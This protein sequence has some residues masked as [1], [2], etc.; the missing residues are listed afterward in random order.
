L[1]RGCGS[2][3]FSIVDRPVFERDTYVATLVENSPP[4]TRVAQ[5]R[6]TDADIGDNGRIMY[7]LHNGGV[8]AITE[9]GG[10]RPVNRDGGSGISS[11]GGGGTFTIDERTGV[12][13]VSGV[14]DYESHPTGYRLMVTARDCGSPEMRSA[15]A[16][17]VIRIVDVNDNAP[18]VRVNTIR[19]ADAERASVPEDAA[20][21][22]FVAHV[23]ATD[24]DAGENGRVECRLTVDRQLQQQ[25]LLLQ[26]KAAT[27]V[28]EPQLYFRLH[29][30][31][32][33]EYHL[34]TGG[35]PLDRELYS[36]SE[37]GLLHNTRTHA[38]TRTIRRILINNHA[39]R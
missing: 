18:T 9:G 29:A 39:I 21:D 4:G 15:D 30:T 26:R 3:Q 34:V 6:A 13:S 23:I 22:T 19:W 35:L 7:Q 17:V 5:V 37:T 27:P 24:A 38:R 1:R 32:D 12:V 16:V 33:A 31:H 11:G 28:A 36:R 14:V 8:G 25:Q 10:N 20:P 2:E